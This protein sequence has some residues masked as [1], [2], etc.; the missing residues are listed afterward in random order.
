MEPT[1]VEITPIFFDNHFYKD[2]EELFFKIVKDTPYATLL[3]GMTRGSEW[4][5]F[6]DKVAEDY[7]KLGNNNETNA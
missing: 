1:S 5:D 2:N 4:T 3:Y 6:V 7:S